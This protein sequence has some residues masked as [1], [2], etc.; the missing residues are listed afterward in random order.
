MIRVVD[1][2]KTFERILAN[3]PAAERKLEP[4]IM[5]PIHHASRPRL[6]LLVSGRH[7]KGGRH[8]R[9]DGEE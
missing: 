7:L 8:D 2:M 1:A 3:D 9:G 5:M 4:R 6:G